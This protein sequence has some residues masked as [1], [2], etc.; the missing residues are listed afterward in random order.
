[1]KSLCPPTSKV[2][3]IDPVETA[4]VAVEVV[5]ALG[6]FEHAL[7]TSATDRKTTAERVHL[8]AFRGRTAATFGNVARGSEGKVLDHPSPF[9]VVDLG[10]R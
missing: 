4:V 3:S 5:S 8:L 10:V 7:A 9:E 2:P 6:P 1:M